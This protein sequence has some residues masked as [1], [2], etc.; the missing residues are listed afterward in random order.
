MPRN[1]PS[2]AAATVPE[3]STSSP[4][5]APLIDAGDQHVGLVLEQ[6]RDRDVHA[7]GRRAVDVVEVV[8]DALDSQRRLERQRVARAAAVTV[9]RDD[10]DLGERRQMLGERAQA[11]CLIAVVVGKEDSQLPF[12]GPRRARRRRRRTQRSAG[13]AA[14]AI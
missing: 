14:G 11:A 6:T 5:L 2:I 8:V 3:Y 10:D 12:P 4:R 7:V 13:G 9:R 1:L